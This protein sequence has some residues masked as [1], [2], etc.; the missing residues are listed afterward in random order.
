MVYKVLAQYGVT[1]SILLIVH[2]KINSEI[3]YCLP[4]NRSLR[5][6]NNAGSLVDIPDRLPAT[7]V[8][9]LRRVDHQQHFLVHILKR[10]N[11]LEFRNII[12]V[13]ME[14][15]SKKT[16]GSERRGRSALLT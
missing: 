4:D 8:H 9:P 11:I 10:F 6:V 7:L 14:N 16:S 12:I 5:A 1:F 13:K 2:S 15:S 3:I